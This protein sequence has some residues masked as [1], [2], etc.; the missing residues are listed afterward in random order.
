MSNS[1]PQEIIKK[2]DGIHLSTEYM[3]V[4]LYN[5]LRR[6]GYEY[7]SDVVGL[8]VDD[9]TK[10]RNFGKQSLDEFL[11]LKAYVY[12]AEEVDVLDFCKLNNSDTHS[13]MQNVGNNVASYVKKFLVEDNK[14]L[15]MD[16]NGLLVSDYPILIEELSVRAF[17]SLRRAGINTVKELA[18]FP[19][20]DFL[21][22]QGVGAKTYEEIFAFVDEKI[23]AGESAKNTVENSEE[24]EKTIDSIVAFFEDY[25]EDIGSEGVRVALFN[26]L[27]NNYVINNELIRIDRHVLGEL[28]LKQPILN[29]IKDK[30]YEMSA[31]SVVEEI[32]VESVYSNLGRIDYLGEK[33]ISHIIQEMVCEKRVVLIDGLIC[34]YRKSLD[35]WIDDLKDNEKLAINLRCEGSTLEEIGKVLNVTRERSRQIISKGF[36]KKPILLEDGYKLIFEKYSFSDEEFA[37]LLNVDLRTINYLKLLYK[38]GINDVYGF[39]ADED[40]PR[41]YVRNIPLAFKDSFLIVENSIAIPLKREKLLEWILQRYFSDIE[42][43][44][45][46]LEE[47]YYGFLR[48][49]DIYD[50]EKL[51]F[52]TSHA[53]EARILDYPYTVLKYGKKVRY[54]DVSAVNIEELLNI[55]NISQYHNSEISTLKLFVENNEL[56]DHIGIQDEYELHNIL[57]KKQFE[58]AK[59][60]I[61]VGRMPFISIGM[62]DRERQVRDL[63]YQLAPISN[64]DLALEYEIRY[65]VKK[66]TVLANFFKEIDIFFHDGIFD[67]EQTQLSDL[68]IKKLEAVFTEDFYMWGEVVDIFS[69][70]IEDLNHDA[71]NA[72]NLKRL[73]FRVYSQYIIRNTYS[74]ADSYFSNVLFG[75][76]TIDLD[77]L[78]VG[79]RSIQSFHACLNGYRDA[80]DLIEIDKNIFMKFEFFVSEIV[81]CTKED[82]IV[83]GRNIVE[84]YSDNIFSLMDNDVSRLL[85]PY[86]ESINTIYFLNSLVRIQKDI[87]TTL[88]TDLCLVTKDGRDPNQQEIY[89]EL[90]R[91]NGAMSFEDIVEKSM[92]EFGLK[93]FKS[94]VAYFLEQA[95]CIEVDSLMESARIISGKSDENKLFWV[96]TQYEKLVNDKMNIISKSDDKIEDEYRSGYYTMFVDLCKINGLSYM[97]ELLLFDLEGECIKNN[98]SKPIIADIIRIYFDWI[99]SLNTRTEETEDI[100]S[101]FFK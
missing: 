30:I 28:A 44:I 18:L 53:F 55:M 22:I 51:L 66:E 11:L 76:D 47:F 27:A 61:T 25:L 5:C 34:K 41:K 85:N 35:E 90:L 58:A 54:F 93:T 81:N 39:I 64:Y 56:M 74:S 86:S 31:D 6:A 95:D 52:S 68:E 19:V 33:L 80:L 82:L 16:N 17:N 8:D 65:G 24:I 70:C 43:T 21:K 3:S 88:F 97:R 101:M 67:L 15:C 23:V 77:S 59:Y 87:R 75:R 32:L 94:K 42:C 60:D 98:V 45:P 92:T 46:E 49:N 36:R 13:T 1:V 26:E 79:M 62:G 71:I 63:L 57:R 37:T 96:D 83:A 12:E 14:F 4:R 84:G 29:L 50:N 40:I 38:K 69:D 20:D 100:L 10:I 2:I 48:N 78:K 99:K 91:R 72:M 7:L 73:G 9:V 89:I